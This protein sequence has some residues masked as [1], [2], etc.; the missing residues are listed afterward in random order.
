[1]IK[2]NKYKH[3]ELLSVSKSK[4][5]FDSTNGSIATICCYIQLRKHGIQTLICLYYKN[6]V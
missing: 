1:M 6:V 2:K 4:N 5:G 3:F